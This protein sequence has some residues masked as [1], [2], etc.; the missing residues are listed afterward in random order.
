MPSSCTIG[1]AHSIPIDLLIRIDERRCRS[2]EDLLDVLVDEGVKLVK[3][4]LFD[5]LLDLIQVLLCLAPSLP[6][7]VLAPQQPN[8]IIL[9]DT[10]AIQKIHFLPELL[11]S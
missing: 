3:E 8:L 10:K 5:S 6:Y 11:Q 4:N 1:H 9:P 2:L 7:F